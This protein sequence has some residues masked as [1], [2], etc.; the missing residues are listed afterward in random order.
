VDTIP[1][2]DF[3]ED[4]EE[5]RVVAAEPRLPVISLSLFGQADD[6]MLKNWGRRLRDDLLAIDGITDVVLS[7][8]RADEI[9]VEVKPERLLEYQ[10]SFAEVAQAIRRTNLDL[11]GGQLRTR[12]ANVAIRT[13]GEHDQVGPIGAVIIRSDPNGR[14][15]RVRD[16]A[17]VI[18]GFED[19][20]VIGR[21]NATP[22]V[23]ATVYKTA[24]QDAIEIASKV[25]AFVAGKTHRPFELPLTERIT[26]RGRQALQVYQQAAAQPYVDLPGNLATHG[27]LARFIE[28]RLDL[29]KRNG[30]WGLLFVFATLLAFLNWRAAFWVMMGL[31]LSV[32]GTLMVMKALG[33][34][35]NLITMFGMIVV[36]GMLVDDA[37]IVAENIVAKIEQG[38]PTKQAAIEGAQEVTWPVVCAIATTIVAFVPLMFVEG[39][40]GDFF[41]V[42]PVIVITALSVSLFE[43]LTI[44]PAHL[45]HQRRT[46]GPADR[47]K[48][49]GWIAR[50]RTAQ[51][52]WLHQRLLTWYERLLSRAISY[53]YVTLAIAVAGMMVALAAV[54]GGRVPFQFMQKM[55]SETLIANLEMAVGTPIADTNAAV[56]YIERATEDLPEVESIYTLIGMQY[57][58]SG[59]SSA[60]RTHLAQVIIELGPIEDREARGLRNSE[61]V[62]RHLRATTRDIPGANALRFEAIHGGPGGAALEIELAGERIE[63][64]LAVTERIKRRLVR[65]DGVHDISDNFEAGRREVQIELLDSARALGLTTQDLAGQVRAA[66]FGL[67]ARKV[68]RD[69]E[70]VKI[71]VRYPASARRR[72]YDVESMWIATP[73]GP[74]VPFAEVARIHEGRSFAAIN[75]L[76]QK[77]TVTLTADI[78]EAVANAQ[79]IGNQLLAE[80]DELREGRA[81]T[82][83]FGGQRREFAKSFGSL[84]QDFAIALLLIYVLLAALFRSYIQPLIVMTAIPFGLIG[85]VIGHYVMGYPMTILSMIGLVALTG[86]VVNDSL[87]LVSFI[88]REV[89]RGAGLVQ[90]VI[91]GGKSRL[92]PIIL[93]S[94]TT[95]AGLAP[96]MAERSFQARFLIPMG[97]SITFGLAFATA[98]TLLVVPSLYVIVDDLR[99]L[100]ARIIRLG[101][102][103]ESEVS[104]PA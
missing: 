8:T 86:I 39:R 9:S 83:Q 59:V 46:R 21:F 90:A 52:R 63:D 100:A 96:L 68:N 48:Q 4:A 25:K 64:L 69:R 41:S 89:A 94:V 104:A 77:R 66:F 73:D 35:L 40:I 6:E 61:Q 30:S 31:V 2:E 17:E 71:M 92:R 26:P 102:K 3:P 82:L 84:R 101:R 91:G 65:F 15:I 5:T 11:P 95:I 32:L 87:I 53:R 50:L 78:D 76:N 23:S 103:P 43:A 16:V 88:N 54:I 38:V 81:V 60:Q 97:I 12:G 57:D 18:D 22:S 51:R 44:L 56:R 24:D 42:L 62:L 37:I 98:L 70:D 13:I 28:G 93:T 58:P 72:V 49:P 75:R 34:T 85:A 99:H 67:E 55:D 1:R 10:L 80:F 45:A 19:V 33:L 29:L 27:N 79:M 14:V 36:L 20:D 7:G 74:L 47:P